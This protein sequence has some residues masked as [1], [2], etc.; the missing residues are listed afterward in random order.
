MEKI[1]LNEDIKNGLTKMFNNGFAS[2]EKTIE[3][4][5]SGEIKRQNL[6]YV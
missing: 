2:N 4:I 1:S 6:C 3:M 5:N